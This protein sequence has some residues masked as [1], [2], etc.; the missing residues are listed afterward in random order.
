[1][2]V[3]VSPVNWVQN[4]VQSLDEVKS[5]LLAFG[6]LAHSR[7]EALKAFL[8]VSSNRMFFC[9]EN[10]LTGAWHQWI[11]EKYK[12]WSLQFDQRRVDPAWPRCRWG[13]PALRVETVCVSYSSHNATGAVGR[14]SRRQDHFILCRVGS[15]QISM[16]IRLPGYDEPDNARLRLPSKKKSETLPCC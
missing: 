5:K 4:P 3:W 1:M 16:A 15:S 8:F 6:S 7:R 13:G 11:R 10:S 2:H 9:L 14:A 12:I